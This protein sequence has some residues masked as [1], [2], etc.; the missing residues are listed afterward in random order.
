[1]APLDSHLQRSRRCR[2]RDPPAVPASL[3]IPTPAFPELS[4]PGVDG[5]CC[6][7]EWGGELGE[8]VGVA[9]EDVVAEPEGADDEVGVD[10]VG[11]SGLGEEASDGVSVVERVHRN[12]LD[13]GSEACLSWVSP[14]LGQDRVGGV[15]RGSGAAAAARKVWASFSLRS[16][17]MRKPASR[18]TG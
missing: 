10:D 5:G 7:A 17:E 12:G 13:E 3:T 15:Q 6:G 16:T 4:G 11:G 1:M 14:D 18:I 9:G 2:Q 8:V